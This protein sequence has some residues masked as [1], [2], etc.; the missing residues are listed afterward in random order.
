MKP[1]A[2]V[3]GVHVEAMSATVL[4]LMLDLPDPVVIRHRIDLERSVLV[5][6]VSDITGIVDHQEIDL[7]HACVPCAVREDVVPTIE[8]VARDARWRSVIVQLPV[9]AQPG[10]VCVVLSQERDLAGAL[11]ISSVVTA[12]DGA[13]LEDDLLGDDLLVERGL[14]TSPEDRRG[15]GETLADLIEYSDV[16]VA[17]STPTPAATDL[18][19]ALARP[20]SRLLT[21]IEQIDAATANE[22]LHDLRR[23]RMW[24]SP[25]REVELPVLE[26]S[27]AWRVELRSERPFHPERLLAGLEKIGAGRHRSKGCFWLPTRPGDVIEWAGAGGQVSIGTGRQWGARAPYTRLTLTGVGTPPGH[28]RPAFESMLVAPDERYLRV[29]HEDG[30]EP[31]LGPIR[32][33]A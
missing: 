1:I 16:I 18:L 21:G 5:R 2:I 13:D 26:A 4:S 6:M 15:V 12:L 31:W 28:L 33:I 7:E 23:T 14:A 17:T 3:T 29:T 22:H 20:G 9:A 24:S 32:D 27:R 25:L 10:Q 8:R 30:F 19:Q 11:G